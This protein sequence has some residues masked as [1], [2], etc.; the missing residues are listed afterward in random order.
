VPVEILVGIRIE[1]E[2]GRGAMG[3]VFLAFDTEIHRRVAI[4][5]IQAFEALPEA[6]RR[7]ARERFLREARAAGRLLHPGIVTIFDVG[8][9]DGIPYLAMEHVAGTTLDAYCREGDLLP[10][11]TVAGLIAHA[12]EALAFAHAR[13]VVHRDVKPANLMRVGTT[14]VK[15]M[16]FGLAKNVAAKMTHDGALFGTPNYM[17]PEQV[18]GEALDGRSDL[19]S[20]GVVLYEMLIGAKPFAGDSVSSVLYRIVHEPPRDL[21]PQLA[22]IP[23]PLG[24]VVAKA[25]AKRREDRF[26][27]GLELAATL[28]RVFEPASA[29]PE[30]SGPR[31]RP[32]PGAPLPAPR[33]EPALP[34]PPGR[35]RRRNIFPYAVG[36]VFVMALVAAAILLSARGTPAPKVSALSAR[37]RSEPP[38]AAILLDGKPVQDGLVRFGRGRAFRRAV[39]GT[40]VP[41]GDAHDRGRGRRT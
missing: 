4:K 3:R 18:R 12:A 22:R 23:P 19:F 7:E 1:R 13:G 11:A 2:L 33:E 26:T 29:A 21:A 36:A 34:P 6:D 16:D 37:V 5:T 41:A 17:S 27:D 35:A 15:V 32:R 25:L 31:P 39:G 9:A 40:G 20:L 24:A 14:A 8:E 38:G 10:P 28:R 30:P